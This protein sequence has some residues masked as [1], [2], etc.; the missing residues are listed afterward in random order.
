MADRR[1]KFNTYEGMHTALAECL[2]YI[3][4]EGFVIDPDPSQNVG[5]YSITD[6]R[7]RPIG[8]IDIDREDCTI[9]FAGSTNARH[10]AAVGFI[11]QALSG[12]ASRS[13]EV[14]TGAAPSHW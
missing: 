4:E 2:N 10:A 7:E 1:F 13:G 6:D 3:E 11:A 5:R 12:A 9:N 14:G 8:H